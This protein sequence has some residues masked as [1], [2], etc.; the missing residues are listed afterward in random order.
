MSPTTGE[1]HL[2]FSSAGM[3]VYGA[4]HPPS[5]ARPGAPVIVFCGGI[6]A[7]FLTVWRMSVLMARDA[8]MRGYPVFRYHPRGDGDSAGSFEDITLERLIDDALAARDYALKISGASRVVWVAARLG[9]VVAAEA[10]RR[11]SATTALVLWAPIHRGSDFFRAMLRDLLFVSAA[12][13]RRPNTTVEQLIER[14]EN[15]GAID[16]LGI[17][18]HR[19]FYQSAV[20]ADLFQSLEGWSGPTLLAQVSSRAQLLPDNEKL[21]A[22]LE[23]HGAPVKMIQDRK[24]PPWALKPDPPWSSAEVIRETGEWLDGLA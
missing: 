13:G 1:R 16:V 8:A 4:F 9:A 21:R 6:G 12:Q 14:V 23:Q 22:M 2:F 10:I 3:P 20:G 5:K 18:L 19:A 11:S 24:E 17:Y 15:D 7:E